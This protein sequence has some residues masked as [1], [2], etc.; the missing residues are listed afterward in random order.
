MSYTLNDFSSN[1]GVMS[2]NMNLMA[3]SMQNMEKLSKSMEDMKISMETFSKSFSNL[4]NKNHNLQLYFIHI[5]PLR[6][7]F[8]TFLNINP[9]RSLITR[10]DGFIYE[11]HSP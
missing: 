5:F 2:E 4:N 9:D 3:T 7:A 8:I 10:F 11:L 6:K 1:I